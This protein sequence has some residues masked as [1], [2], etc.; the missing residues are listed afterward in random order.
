MSFYL[1]DESS[2]PLYYRTSFSVYLVVLSYEG[3]NYHTHMTEHNDSDFRVYSPHSVATTRDTNKSDKYDYYLLS[4]RVFVIFTCIS[5]KVNLYT[6]LLMSCFCDLHLVL[7][8]CDEV[9]EYIL[10]V[11]KRGPTICCIIIFLYST[12][13]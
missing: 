12:V 11:N 10:F 7:I 8:F 3:C 1:C 9:I 6:T 4:W 13:H 2:S 5:L